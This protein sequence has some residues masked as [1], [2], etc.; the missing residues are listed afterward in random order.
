MSLKRISDAIESLNEK[1]GTVLQWLS[2]F[3]VLVGAYNAIA[4]FLSKYLQVNLSSNSLLEIQW[5]FF[6]A[7]FLL[8]AAYGL[9]H[10][11]HVR[12]DVFYEKFSP[13][14]KEKINFYGN[15]FLLLPFCLTLFVASLPAVINSWKVWELSPDPGGLPRYPVKTLLPLSF[16]LLFLQGL[17]QTIKGYYSIKEKKYKKE[18]QG[19]HV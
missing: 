15:L 18:E 17:S 10:N 13:E 19:G 8:A 3:M 12:V 2:L 1:A 7:L 14:K 11:V 16:L 6:S 9:K 5:Y 4:R